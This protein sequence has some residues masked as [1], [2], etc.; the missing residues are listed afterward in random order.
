MS[1]RDR[2][3]V[4][5]GGRSN[6]QGERTVFRRRRQPPSG[7]RREIVVGILVEHQPAAVRQRRGGG[8]K[9]CEKNSTVH[10]G[11]SKLE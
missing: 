8:A 10:R 7:A 2:L 6:P 5:R 4:V 9:R 3:Q 1:R 11:N